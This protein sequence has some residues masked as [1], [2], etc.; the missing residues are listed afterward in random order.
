M[1]MVQAVAVHLPKVVCGAIHRRIFPATTPAGTNSIRG[2]A[3][4]GLIRAPGNEVL[5]K[6]D[7]VTI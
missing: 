6:A 4:K 7:R 2:V 1:N 3:S 5:A